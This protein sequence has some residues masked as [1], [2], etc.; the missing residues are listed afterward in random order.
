MDKTESPAAVRRF[1]TRVHALASTWIEG[2]RDE[3][4][5]FGKDRAISNMFRCPWRRFPSDHGICF[6]QHLAYLSEVCL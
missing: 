1:L 2:D 6:R 4:P 5:K 3:K